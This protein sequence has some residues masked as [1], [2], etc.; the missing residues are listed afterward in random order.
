RVFLAGPAA[1]TKGMPAQYVIRTTAVD[2]RPV[3]AMIELRITDK[4]EKAIWSY[5]GHADERGW[6]LATMPRIDA[7]PPAAQLQMIAEYRGVIERASWT[8]PATDLHA[9]GGVTTDYARYSPEQPIR[10]RAMTTQ[11]E[12][13][14]NEMSGGAKLNSS[15]SASLLLRPHEGAKQTILPD[16][17]AAG[18]TAVGAEFTNAPAGDYRV[19]LHS[20]AEGRSLAFAPVTVLAASPFVSVEFSQPV[21]IPGERVRAVIRP[22]TAEKA[23]A[24]RV[25]AETAGKVIAQQEVQ[26]RGADS[27]RFEFD[28]PADIE[29][30]GGKLIAEL[31]AEANADRAEISLPIRQLPLKIDFFPES[32][33]LVAGLENRVYVRATDAAGLPLRLAGVVVND[34]NDEVALVETGWRGLGAMAFRPEPGRD[35]RLK[36]LRPAGLGEAPLPDVD[37]DQ[38]VVLAAGVGVFSPA[39]VLEFNLRSAEAGIPLVVSAWRRGVQV[40]QTALVTDSDKRGANLLRIPLIDNAGGVMQIRVHDCR[41]APPHLS[42]V[43]WIYQ[44]PAAPP[45]IELTRLHNVKPTE[46]RWQVRVMDS[47]KGSSSPE[48]QAVVVAWDLKGDVRPRPVS[49][50]RQ[51]LFAPLGRLV[52]EL[53][54]RPADLKESVAVDLLLGTQTHETASEMAQGQLAAAEEGRL[55]LVY[56][57]LPQVGKPYQEAL[58]EYQAGPERTVRVLTMLCFCI[59]VAL[60][61]LAVMAGLL[62]IVSGVLLWVPVLCSCAGCLVVGL[63]LMGP[64]PVGSLETTTPFTSN[65]AKPGLEVP[66][67]AAPTE[68]TAGE[69]AVKGSSSESASAVEPDKSATGA[70]EGQPGAAAKPK[71]D[72]PEESTADAATSAAL[73]GVLPASAVAPVG[74]VLYWN[75]DVELSNGEATITCDVPP[76][77]MRLGILIDAVGDGTAGWLEQDLEWASQ[78]SN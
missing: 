7:L 9:V 77:V 66:S 45:R 64:D 58:A 52:T 63:V 49:N 16:T 6:R 29:P 70:T 40:G 61:L 19:E 12:A 46:A 44:Q 72:R 39:D 56:D 50:S 76:G 27:V 37:P 11:F 41:T 15:G 65:P 55:P 25:A 10:A 71:D 18:E 68:D 57:N 31:G 4:A 26:L 43:R 36:I 62:G 35:Y 51:L 47:T 5:S 1:L 67:P 54:D 73:P 13:R 53:A 59:A 48:L 21:Y 24:L 69:N 34:A 22:R 74:R 30:T 75:S 38:R 20:G 17:V 33:Q 28:L 2:G 14:T 60:V 42:A 78:Q 23:K 8:I 32:G 3:P